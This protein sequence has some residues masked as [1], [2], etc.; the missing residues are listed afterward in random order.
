[1]DVDKETESQIH[2]LQILEGNLQNLLMQKQ[3]FELELNESENAI[4]ELEKASQEVYKIVGNIMIK[5]DK[6]DLLKELKQKTDLLKLRLKSLESQEK[7]LTENS[8]ELRE[9]I[10]SKIQKK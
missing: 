8:E 6:A 3:A 10:L 5:S 2:Q 9:K 4:Q 1:M 7:P